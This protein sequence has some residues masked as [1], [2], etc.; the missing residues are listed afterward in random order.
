MSNVKKVDPTT[1]ENNLRNN[2]EGKQ[3]EL[4][5]NT[6]DKWPDW[7][8]EIFNKLMQITT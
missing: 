4:A 7:K 6:I 8:K 2:P 3:Y 5:K 1:A